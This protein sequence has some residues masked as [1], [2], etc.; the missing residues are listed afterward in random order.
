[1]KF[2]DLPVPGPT[3]DY[4]GYGSRVPKVVWPEDA[5]L[6]VSLCINYEEGSEYAHPA[7]DARNDTLTELSYSLAAEHRDLNAE[8]VYEFGSRVGVFRLLRLFEEYKIETT[9]FAAAVAIERNPDAAEILRGGV[10]EICGHGWRW[11]EHWLFSR[12][13][14]RE[15]LNAAIESFTATCGRRPVGWCCRYSPSVHTRELLVEEG[16]FLY[17]SDAYNDDLPYFT[18]V[19]GKR[20]LVIPYSFVYNDGKYFWLKASVAPEISLSFAAAVSTSCA[21]R[22]C[23]DFRK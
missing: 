11:S 6:V 5:K 19:H 20:H 23:K 8:S 7:G 17:D 22:E 2:V 12:D 9:F 1:M 14:E 18:A 13:E 3:R 4:V 10:H 21:S 16:G 15:R